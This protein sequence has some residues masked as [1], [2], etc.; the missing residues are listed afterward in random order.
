MSAPAPP[1][2]PTEGPFI[3][4]L[5]VNARTPEDLE[6]LAQIFSS[7]RALALEQGAKAF[8]VG[9]RVEGLAVTVFEVWNFSALGYLVK[10]CW[11][12]VCVRVCS[13]VGIRKC[14][15]VQDLP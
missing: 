1:E 8:L 3:F 5:T 6:E 14:Q 4:V 9:K 2:P 10:D 12:T 15:G 11:L 7:H 13:V